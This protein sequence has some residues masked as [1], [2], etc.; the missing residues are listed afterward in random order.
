MPVVTN[1]AT[2]ADR[3]QVV[4]ALRGL[5]ATAVATFHFTNGNPRFLHEGILHSVGRN[6]WAGVEVFFVISGFII[7]WSLRRS[8]YRL[9]NFG[10]FLTRRI[11]RLDPPYLVAV[12]TVVLL[13]FLSSKAPGFA[14]AP[15]V[16][17]WARLFLHVGYLNGFAHVPWFDIVYW[18][19]AIE[20]QFYL[21]IGLI[22]PLIASERSL[23]ATLVL[24]LLGG[25]AF[26]LKNDV[27][28]P[29]WFFPFLIGISVFRLRSGLMS[30]PFFLAH[31]ALLSVGTYF[32]LGA[33]PL[34]AC[35]IAA[36]AIS[37][38][39]FRVYRPFLVLGSLS[40]P[41]Y[42]V[43]VPI[44]GRVIN[45]A[46]RLDSGGFG[47]LLQVFAAFAVSLSAAYVLHRF[48]EVPAQRWSRNV[49]WGRAR[50]PRAAPL[51]PAQPTP[52]QD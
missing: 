27:F 47:K 13:G 25:S 8:G 49:R 39:H 17:S 29:A 41:L 21:L 51:N 22:F 10:A 48:V 35:L 24:A 43:H 33:I 42:L 20:L 15:F 31:A 18:T 44:G 9:G 40:Y 46:S 28:L 1:Q 19:L 34:A 7:P 23:T 45:L 2:N 6:G 5:A 4:D 32:T 12:L 16:F 50:I 3:I 30:A 52:N 11:V 37:W 38:I 26:L 14:G 36:A